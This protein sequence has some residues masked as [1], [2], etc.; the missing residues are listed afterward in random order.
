MHLLLWMNIMLDFIGI[1]FAE[2]WETGREQKN[3][4]ENVSNLLLCSN[5]NPAP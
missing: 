3:L 4:N 2:L 5:A 1:G